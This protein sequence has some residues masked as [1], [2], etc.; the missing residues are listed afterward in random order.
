MTENEAIEEIKK[1]IC[2]ERPTQHI[3]SDGCMKGND[4]C[5]LSVA[6]KALEEIQQY[7]AIGTVDEC[8]AAVDK[9][10]AKKPYL[11]QA[12][13][14]ECWECPTCDSFIGYEVD[15]RDEHYRENNCPKTII[16]KRW[17][18]RTT[19]SSAGVVLRGIIRAD[20]VGGS[21]R[22]ERTHREREI[23]KRAIEIVKGGGVNE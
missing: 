11:E 19:S 23:V 10:T 18:S 17:H 22:P 2:G 8:R 4:K 14:D 3:C 16:T 1:K 9:Q 21:A 12:E 5:A 15:C 6:I 13:M 20:G 7:R